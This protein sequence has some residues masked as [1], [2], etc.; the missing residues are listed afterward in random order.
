MTKNFTNIDEV[1]D[2]LVQENT[3][4][5]NFTKWIDTLED[6]AITSI[7]FHWARE[8]RNNLGLWGENDLTKW[9]NTIGIAHADDMSGIITTSL[10]RKMNN[11]DLD[12]SQQVLKYQEHWKKFGFPDGVPK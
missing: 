10:H 7:H 3:G 11:K 6:E 2:Y 8:L 5:E 12:I 1:L 4:N 9:F